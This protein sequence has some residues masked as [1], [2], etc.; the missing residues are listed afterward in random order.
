M[1]SVFGTSGRGLETVRRERIPVAITRLPLRWWWESPTDYIRRLWPYHR[2]IL[3]AVARKKK[4]AGLDIVRS[5]IA[6]QEEVHPVP[7]LSPLQRGDVLERDGYECQICGARETVFHVDHR[8]PRSRGGTNADENLWTLC[9]TCN[10]RK[11]A[12]TVEEFM[13]RRSRQACA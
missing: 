9:A 12:R 1:T 4:M 6:I 2:G 7:P 11:G 3:F 13:E 5:W 8:H 10:L